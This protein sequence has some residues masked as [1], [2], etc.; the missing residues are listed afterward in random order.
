MD[1]GKPYIMS[2]TSGGLCLRESVILTRSY[3]EL[4]DWNAARRLVLDKNLLQAHMASSAKRTV[5]EVLPRLQALSGE[6]LTYLLPASEQDQKYLLWLA[7]CRRHRFIADFMVEVV[8]D[9]Y[10]SLKDTVGTEE[11]NLFW[12]QKAVTHHEI[13][14]ISDSTREKLRA[15]LF[16]MM[17]E[18]GIISKDNRIN[19]VILS[20]PIQSLLQSGDTYEQLWFTT[21][22][23]NGR[24]V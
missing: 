9:R 15:V 7:I 6:E 20:P 16:K 8:H 14:K 11:F 19:S 22:D 21:T 1:N 3:F 24:R 18:V 4:Q 23:T 12:M 2:F 10:I 13:E 17:R 5:G